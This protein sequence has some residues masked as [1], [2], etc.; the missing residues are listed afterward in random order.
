MPMGDGMTDLFIELASAMLVV[1]LVLV[2]KYLLVPKIQK[3]M[4]DFTW[5]RYTQ[6]CGIYHGSSHWTKIKTYLQRLNHK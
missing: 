4:G 6:Q 5:D 2:L 1:V 3:E